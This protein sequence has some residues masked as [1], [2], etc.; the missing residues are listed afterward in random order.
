MKNT[1]A[2]VAAGVLLFAGSAALL[3]PPVIGTVDLERVFNDIDAR[4]Q[5]EAGLKVAMQE[6]E[7]RLQGLR[8]DAESQKADLE[9]LLA[10]TQKYKDQEDELMQ[11][12]LD[13][14]AMSEFVNLKLDATR[15]EMRRDLFNEIIAEAEKYAVNNGI[16]II[17][18][19]D[20]QLPIQ[21]GTDIQVVQQLALRRILYVNTT[22]D[23]TDEL[24]DWINGP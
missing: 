4:A 24:I 13:F 6:F 7:I 20:S 11:S 16:D 21:E 9:G 19:N 18:T 22:Y 5:A 14:R 10:G 1:H 12:A 2:F 23:I 17:I 8:A 15:A 3:N